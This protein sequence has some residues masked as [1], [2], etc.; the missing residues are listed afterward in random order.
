MPSGKPSTLR[1]FGIPQQFLEHGTRSQVL[2]DIGLT[3]Q[4]IT[5]EVV[6]TVSALDP[7]LDPA[8]PAVQP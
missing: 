5:R 4:E 1:D 2:A 7:A 8:P 3:A 6:E